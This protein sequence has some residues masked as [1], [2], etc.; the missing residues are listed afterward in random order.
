MPASEFVFCRPSPGIFFSWNVVSGFLWAR[1]RSAE[2][3]GSVK[4]AHDA[5]QTK[6]YGAIHDVPGRQMQWVWLAGIVFKTAAQTASDQVHD[7]PEKQR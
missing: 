3:V 5:P 1:I 4:L 7:Q 6:N 2:Y